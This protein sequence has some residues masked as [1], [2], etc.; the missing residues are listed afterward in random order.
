MNEILKAAVV[1]KQGLGEE[2]LALINRQ[3]LRAFGAE[4]VF[5]FRLAACNDQ[6]D[7]DF[8]RFTRK[9][10]EGLA[11]L[12]VGKPVL[13]DHAWSAGKQTARVYAADVE[14]DG[15]GSR[16][17]LRCYIPRSD[18]AAATIA[19][20]EGGILREASVGCAVGRV[21]CSICGADQVQ[22]LC[23]HVPGREYDGEVCIMDLDEPT[24]AYE[25]SLVAVPAQ[26]GAGVIKSKRYGGTG[27]PPKKPPESGEKAGALALARARQEQ[28]EKRY[29]GIRT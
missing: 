4:E 6:V 28:E 1:T 12:Y 16:L 23:Q 13:L 21:T 18:A 22:A 15:E 17:V 14:T 25:V 29:G 27:E 2:D 9:A 26:P 8:E 11:K 10:L 5:A 19:A 24:D 3:T 20:I 7:R